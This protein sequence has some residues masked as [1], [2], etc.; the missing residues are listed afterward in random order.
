MKQPE[1]GIKISSLRKQK[2][3]TQEELVE[4][5]NINVRTLQRIENGEVTPRSYT[6]K[7]ILSALD[8]D[9]GEL[10]GQES[11]E[12]DLN[13]GDSNERTSAR[14][15][16]ATALVAGILYLVMGAF[17]G[18]SDWYRFAEDTFV[19]GRG[20]HIGIKIGA[21]LSYVLFVYGF[22]VAG[23]LLQNYLLKVI[24]V[25]LMAVY[26][27][28]Y[29]YDILSLFQENVPVEAVLV[30]EALIVGTVGVLLGIAILKS[31]KKIGAVAYAAG[32]LEIL[33]SFLFLTVLLAVVGLF[34]QFPTIIVELLLLHK[35]RD[36]LSQP[37]PMGKESV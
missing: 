34:T 22:L 10:Y 27:L 30:A 18:I 28:F 20:M 23:K 14:T 16:L 32:G 35:I 26:L 21:L 3:F 7:T 17:E 31:A 13:V 36:M 12:T 11:F 37:S 25:L 1:L 24:S 8:H 19:Y 9:Y 33:T 5:C 29:T 2:G 4:R 6:L 15:A